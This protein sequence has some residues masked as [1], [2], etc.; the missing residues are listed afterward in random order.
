MKTLDLTSHRSEAGRIAIGM[1][2][3]D[4]RTL[5]GVGVEPDGRTRSARRA[6]KSDS[7]N[8]SGPVC[9]LSIRDSA[10][11][12]VRHLVRPEA[13]TLRHKWGSTPLTRTEFSGPH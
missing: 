11:N 7:A 10:R 13:R 3:P 12:T 5:A 8:D 9:R 2:V 4:A 1:I 6:A